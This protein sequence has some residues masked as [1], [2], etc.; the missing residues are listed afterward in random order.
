MKRNI[1]LIQAGLVIQPLLFWLG[2]TPDGLIYDKKYSEYPCLLKIKC[3]S[4]R[5]NSSPQDLLRGQSFYLQENKN[6]LFGKFDIGIS[7]SALALTSASP[8]ALQKIYFVL[9]SLYFYLYK[10]CMNKTSMVNHFS[11]TLADLPGSFM[12]C[13]EQLFCRKPVST[14]F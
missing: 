8:S 7:A 2:A 9:Q 10:F 3:L 6:G 12:Q 1:F 4:K 14:Y 13:L 5:R 11:S